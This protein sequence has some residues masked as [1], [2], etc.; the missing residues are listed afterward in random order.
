MRSL[1]RA[2]AASSSASG[3]SPRSFFLWLFALELRRYLPDCLWVCDIKHIHTDSH[4]TGSLLKYSSCCLLHSISLYRHG[5]NTLKSGAHAGQV[6]PSYPLLPLYIVYHSRRSLFSSPRPTSFSFSFS[7]RLSDSVRLSPAQSASSS[8]SSPPPSPVQN[9]PPL[10]PHPLYSTACFAAWRHD[11]VPPAG[12]LPVGSWWPGPAHRTY[13]CGRCGDQCGFLPSWETACGRSDYHYCSRD[14]P[15][16]W[17]QGRPECKPLEASG[18]VCRPSPHVGGMEW[19]SRWYPSQQL[20][21]RGRPGPAWRAHHVPLGCKVAH[22]W[23]PGHG[24]V[25]YAPDG[26]K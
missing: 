26:G 1:I 7:S 15:G 11:A 12:G 9:P 3:N 18:V 14:A 21:I 13:C 2:E 25:G 19:E 17:P 5:G 20:Y 8:P 24:R 4:P 23:S 6:R 22:N 10:H 16:R